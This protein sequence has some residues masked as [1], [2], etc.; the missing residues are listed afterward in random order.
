MSRTNE[1]APPTLAELT[2]RYLQR[3]VS[4]RDAGLAAAETGEVVPFESAPVQ[5]V[6]P[7]LAWEEAG[8]AV[9]CFRPA[10][11]GSRQSPPEWPVLVAAHEPV[12]A[13]AFA[14]GNFPQLVRDL[15]PLLQA[16]DL[17]TLRPT[18]GVPLP[19][20]ALPDWAAEV[21]KKDDWDQRLLA[22]GTLRLARQFDSA[23]ELAARHQAA[24]PAEWRAAWANE[25]AALAWH[26][27]HADEAA[28]LWGAH[29]D[30]V[31]VFFN[32]GMADL[33]LG[34][35]VEARPWL[36]RAVAQLPDDSSWH[37]LGRLYL[38][39]AEMHA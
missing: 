6:D 19:A 24:V 5:P 9:R 30:G 32:R 4:A 14:T 37:H 26:R 12:A 35:P 27:G 23:V 38:T 17:T 1:P 13:L 36:T 20:P 34:R 8:A 39:L 28:A 11:N 21:A 29:A 22:L 25:Q 3:Q 7:R 10:K 15:H 18:G 16:T 2:A 31:P 33:F